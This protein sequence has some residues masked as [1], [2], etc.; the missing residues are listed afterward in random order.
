MRVGSELFWYRV[1]HWKFFVPA[2][3]LIWAVTAFILYVVGYFKDS[4]NV[5]LVGFGL[6][7]ITIYQ[8]YRRDPDQKP[9]ERQRREIDM[10]NTAYLGPISVISILGAFWFSFSE[11]FPT[12]WLPTGHEDWRAIMWLLFSVGAASKLMNQR[13]RALPP[14]DDEEIEPV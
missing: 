6:L 4:E 7:A 8:E 13:L 11:Y 9:D 10:D 3:A 5:F 12:I 1:R 2:A 14:L